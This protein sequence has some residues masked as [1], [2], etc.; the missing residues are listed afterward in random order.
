LSPRPGKARDAS[1]RFLFTT[2]VWLY[3]VGGGATRL[4]FEGVLVPIRAVGLD[5][6]EPHQHA[7]LW[8]RCICDLI[9]IGILSSSQGKP[10]AGAGPRRQSAA[11]IVMN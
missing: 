10:P 6:C 4:A 11:L 1:R 3:G 8:A 9:G 7:A 5:S 2:W